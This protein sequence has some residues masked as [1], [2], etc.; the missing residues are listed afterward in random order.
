MQTQYAP[1]Q[2]TKF[3]KGNRGDWFVD[4][5]NGERLP[6]LHWE[7]RGIG[8]LYHQD[9]YYDPAKLKMAKYIEALNQGRAVMT[10]SERLPGRNTVGEGRLKRVGYIEGVVFKVADVVNDPVNGLTCRIVGSEIV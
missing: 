10:K 2:G 3:A 8:N 9:V 5:R 6:C 1:R 7:Y 4:L